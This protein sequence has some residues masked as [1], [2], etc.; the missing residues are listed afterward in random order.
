[1]VIAT[2]KNLKTLFCISALLFCPYSFA[3]NTNSDSMK[4]SKPDKAQLSRLEK[5]VFPQFTLF[6]PQI[7]DIESFE[8][9]TVVHLA[10]KAADHSDAYVIVT[11][12]NTVIDI[13]NYAI[14]SQ[15]DI[16][17]NPAYSKLAEKFP[18]I[19]IWPGQHDYPKVERLADGTKQLQF[20]YRLLNGCHACAV[21]GVAV[22]GF[23]FDVNHHFDGT[24]LLS[25]LPPPGKSDQ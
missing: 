3:E 18:N 20:N 10:V 23:N 14:L 4:P 24:V 8:G 22:I 19:S 12:D 17:K 2:W 6:Q 9:L 16:K 7:T 21:G 13:D 1:M 25:L 5:A 15:I 11:P